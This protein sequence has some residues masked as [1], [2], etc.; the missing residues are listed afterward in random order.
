MYFISNNKNISF[1]EGWMSCPGREPSYWPK[2]PTPDL[3]LIARSVIKKAVGYG[4]PLSFSF[5]ELRLVNPLV[6]F[7]GYRALG[8]N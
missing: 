3:A 6:H 5:L 4:L 7:P 8:R 2:I 1:S